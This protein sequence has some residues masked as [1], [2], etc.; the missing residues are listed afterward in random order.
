MFSEASNF[1]AG[2]DKTF[3][4]IMGIAFFFLIGLT[5]TM[6]VFAIK[7][8]RKKHPV[9]VQVKDNIAL[10][11]TWT[12]IPL[13]LVLAMFYYGYTAFLPMRNI[14]KDAMPV[15]V[16]GKMWDWTFDYG[17]GKIKKDT[18]WVPLNKAV[19]LEMVSPDVTHSFYVPAF[20]VKEDLVPGTTTHMWFIAQQEGT[21][22]ILCAEYCGLRHSYMEG[23]VRVVPEKEFRTWLANLKAADK[24]GPEGLV[25]IR[26]NSCTGC[27]SL[28]GSKLV[29]PSF[30]GL[31]GTKRK[32]EVNGTEKE[33]VADSAY[34]EQSV[35]DPDAAVVNGYPKGVMRSY[36]N[37]IKD[38]DIA[39]IVKYLSARDGNKK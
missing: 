18:L 23:R 2:V 7:Y 6:I 9:P 32:V 19:K 34:I 27:H 30:K 11:I 39:K 13:V 16:I 31:F 15:K 28:D 26:N 33:V 36:K 17:N 20:R 22:E 14:P 35:T 3:A 10:E 4:F 25:L 8:R 29:G 5:V 37:V 21:Y 12:I 38:E 1:S 24:N